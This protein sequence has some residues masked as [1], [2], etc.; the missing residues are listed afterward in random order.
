MPY[1]V[2]TSMSP[3]RVDAFTACPMAFRFSSIE[4]LPEP[5]SPHAMKG[6]LVH[7]ALELLFC[8]HPASRTLQAGLSALD[9]AVTELHGQADWAALGLDDAAEQAFVDEAETLVRRYFTMEDPTGVRDIGLELRLQ[10]Q[11]GPLA[12]RGII[13]RLDLDDDGE[14]VV[15]DYKTGRPPSPNYEQNRLA[16]VHFYAYLCQQAFGKRPAHV[17]LYYLSTG[18]VIEAHPT[19]QSVRFLPRRTE[20]VWKAVER[21]CTNDDF[22]PRPSGLCTSCAFKAWC[23]AFGGS[24]ENAAAEAPRAFGL[25]AV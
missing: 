16:G 12:L 3:S 14:L 18:E 5:P 7:R 1:P 8:E 21:A 19:E 22:R 4:H 13:D 9:R 6:S 20:A 24:P 23:P 15:V 2:P 25:A 10:V 17:R 11:A